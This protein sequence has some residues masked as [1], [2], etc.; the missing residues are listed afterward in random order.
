M[1]KILSVNV[2]LYL[3]QPQFT[4][5]ASFEKLLILCKLIICEDIVRYPTTCIFLRYDS[6]RPAVCSVIVQPSFPCRPSRL[7]I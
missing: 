4:I 2:S 3:R 5:F 6:F 7:R 1:I